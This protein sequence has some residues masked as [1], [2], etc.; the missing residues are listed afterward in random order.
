VVS[1]VKIAALNENIE[2]F[3]EHFAVGYR[4]PDPS[5]FKSS[6]MGQDKKKAILNISD[7]TIT[8]MQ[9]ATKT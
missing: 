3:R 9:S 8:T 7:T 1:L 5:F 6:C 2:Y 4:A